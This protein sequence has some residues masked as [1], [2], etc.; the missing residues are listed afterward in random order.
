MSWLRYHKTSSQSSKP[1]HQWVS[2]WCA[3]YLQKSTDKIAKLQI[4]VHECS[5]HFM[6]PAGQNTRKTTAA[7]KFKEDP[8]QAFLSML[9]FCICSEAT[10]FD[11]IYTSHHSPKLRLRLLLGATRSVVSKTHQVVPLES[12]C[13]NVLHLLVKI[14]QTQPTL[15]YAIRL[16]Y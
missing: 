7:G 2:K 9:M 11:S 12:H 8:Q 15:V 3:M 1:L 4:R 13:Y 5:W 10:R 6:T 14:A 16:S